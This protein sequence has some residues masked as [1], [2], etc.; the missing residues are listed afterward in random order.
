MFSSGRE[1]FKCFPKFVH[2][3][4]VA[5]SWAKPSRA[6]LQ[7]DTP[8]WGGVNIQ[9][10]KSS[11]DQDG[12]KIEAAITEEKRD[13]KDETYTGLSPLR[14]VNDLPCTRSM[15]NRGGEQRDLPLQDSKHQ[16]PHP[17][18][19]FKAAWHGEDLVYN[20]GMNFSWER[21]GKK[22]SSGKKAE[23]DISCIPSPQDHHSGV[24]TPHI[25]GIWWKR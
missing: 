19:F 3:R 2:S 1:R 6:V 17:S 25:C 11:E 14:S 22:I 21:N 10:S 16:V 18:S 7:N 9:I 4:R 8:R 5:R 15:R 20:F 23:R 12:G 24:G 13:K